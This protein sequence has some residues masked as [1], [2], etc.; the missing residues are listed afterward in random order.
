MDTKILQPTKQNIMACADEIKSGGVV[1]FPTETVYGLGASALNESA[2]AKIFECKGR[3]SDNPLIVHIGSIQQIYELASEVTPLG[4][5][6]AEHFMPDAITLVFNKKSHIPSVVTGG[7]DT[8]ALRIPNNQIA[9]DFIN[10]CGVPL[11]AP[12]ANLSTTPSPTLASHVYSDLKGRI[13]YVLDGG[14]CQIGLESTVV[15]VRGET[16]IILRTGGVSK[17]Q[18]EAVTGSVVVANSFLKDNEKA[19][20]PG[21]KYKHY[22]PKADVVA[23]ENDKT[24]VD[25]I[26]KEYQMQSKSGKKC[27][28][29]CLDSMINNF[30]SDVQTISVGKNYDEYAKSLYA[31]LRSCDEKGYDHIIAMLGEKNDISLAINNR[32]LK[33]CGGKTI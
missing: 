2:I 14:A 32:L 24:A 6:L 17:E 10:A 12:S 28:V 29:M 4:K 26:L 1:G 21:M 31:T 5:K 19:L 8:V 3:P 11:A 20:S 13:K 23:C 15:D 7:L 30:S 16:P 25:K 33:A 22:S 27:V 9:I 18:I